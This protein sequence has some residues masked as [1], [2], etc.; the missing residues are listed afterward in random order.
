M[1]AKTSKK[2]SAPEP[3]PPMEQDD[4]IDDDMDISEDEEGNKMNWVKLPARFNS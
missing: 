4:V 1:S 2:K 3:Q